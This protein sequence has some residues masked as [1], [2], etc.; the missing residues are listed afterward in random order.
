MVCYKATWAMASL[1]PGVETGLRVPDLVDV[2]DNNIFQVASSARALMQWSAFQAD[3]LQLQRY[4]QHLTEPLQH[5]RVSH[6]MTELLFK[7]RYPVFDRRIFMGDLAYVIQ[8]IQRLLTDTPYCILFKYILAVSR[9]Q[10]GTLPYLFHQTCAIILPF[11]P[12]IPLDLQ[13]QLCRSLDELVLL[14]LET[15]NTADSAWMD[16][17]VYVLASCWLPSPESTTIPPPLLRYI[18]GRCSDGAVSKLIKHIPKASQMWGVLAQALRN[19]TSEKVRRDI[20]TAIWR[21][22]YLDGRVAELSGLRQLHRVVADLDVPSLSPS[23]L[24]LVRRRYLRK[25]ADRCD[26]LSIVAQMRDPLL[27]QPTAVALEPPVYDLGEAERD[28]S[29]SQALYRRVEEAAVA[30]VAEYVAL[31]AGPHPFP[32]K[33][34]DTFQ[35]IARYNPYWLLTV[36]ESH[37]T[38]LSIA[39]REAFGNPRCAELRSSMI[40][41]YMFGIYADPPP[42]MEMARPWL[43]NREARDTIRKTFAEYAE[44][45]AASAEQDSQTASDL[46]RIQ[47]MLHRL[48]SFYAAA[49]DAPKDSTAS[50]YT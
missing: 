2:T 33:A 17:L 30:I 49:P 22:T 26:S 32:Y 10:G 12:V 43:T 34:T 50:G 28:S 8:R 18:N 29:A 23:V 48:D 11:R 37:Q 21:V 20:L 38:Q 4:L 42:V 19:E 14:I 7:E 27:P 41:S 25:L 13:D 40:R 24:A 31:C 39:I 9:Q 16:E 36:H 3:A 47:V 5:T 6:S 46:N 44:D 35:S 1:L 45:L 15:D